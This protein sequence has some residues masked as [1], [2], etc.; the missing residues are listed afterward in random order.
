MRKKIFVG[1]SVNKSVTPSIY[2]REVVRCE[3]EPT[4]AEYGKK[5]FAM[6]GPFKTVRGANFMVKYGSGNPHTQDV[7]STE[8]LAKL[9][10]HNKNR[11]ICL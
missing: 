10:F 7:A 6:I 5:F 4:E 1:C 3:V 9:D 2:G 8:R 11:K